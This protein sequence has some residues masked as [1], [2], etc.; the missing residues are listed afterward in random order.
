MKQPQNVVTL[1][2]S[3]TL[4]CSFF[5]ITTSFHSLVRPPQ[6]CIYVR[7][8]VWFLLTTFVSIQTMNRDY[9]LSKDFFDHHLNIDTRI[10]C[11]SFWRDAK[12]LEAFLG[13]YRRFSIFDMCFSPCWVILGDLLCS[14]YCPWYLRFTY[15][16]TCMD[17]GVFVL[18][19]FCQYVICPGIFLS[20]FCNFSVINWVAYSANLLI[21]NFETLSICTVRL[22]F[23]TPSG[24]WVLCSDLL[25]EIINP[26]ELTSSRP[27]NLLSC[28]INKIEYKLL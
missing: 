28:L 1:K 25:H 12:G 16:I 22:Y 5:T 24:C 26:R 6:I 15:D 7:E 18:S 8:D 11:R 27:F 14:P 20:Q 3:V 17:V 23:L 10:S 2:D 19:F 21:V 9:V 13:F 4:K